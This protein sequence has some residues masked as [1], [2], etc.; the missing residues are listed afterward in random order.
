MSRRYWSA[1]SICSGA[2]AIVLAVL[3]TIAYSDRG[4]EITSIE[5]RGWPPGPWVDPMEHYA[6]VDLAINVD[7]T[8]LRADR[9]DAAGIRYNV[10]NQTGQT[11]RFVADAYHHIDPGL[12]S[13]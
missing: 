12:I 4:I 7:R 3:G 11:W 2:F 10:S 9:F 13:I 1:L 6:H 5:E 8:E